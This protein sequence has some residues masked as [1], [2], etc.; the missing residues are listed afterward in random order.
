MKE[1]Q[2]I[3]EKKSNPVL[4]FFSKTLNGMA[5]GL[6]ATLIIGT[7]FGTIGTLFH[8]GAGNGFCDFMYYI[9]NDKNGLAFILQVLTGAGI[10]V[11][12]ALALKF[13]PLKTVV[14]AAVGEVAALFSLSTKFVTNPTD[15]NFF[16]ISGFKIG[17]P[18]TIY[19]VCIA[20]A[21]AIKYTLVKKTPVDILIVPLFG[22]AV[23][24]TA[25]L[26]IRYPAIY[27]T[28]GIQWLVNAGTTAVPFV[29]GIVVAVLMGMAL[30]APISSAAIAAMIFVLPQ[31]VTVSM[32]LADPQLAGLVVASGAAVIGCSTQMVGFAIQSRKD[33]P[34]G[35]VIS[36]GIG[37]S[38]LQ[39]KNILKNPLIWLPTIIASAILGPISTCWIKVICTGSSAG[40]GTAG[41]V[42]Q[43]GTISSM[44]VDNWQVWVGIFVLQII[45]PAAIVFGLDLL[46][47][48][49]GWIKDGDLKV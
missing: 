15:F 11:G 40:M 43:I 24:L 7:I 13:D 38:M 39:F 16:S 21:L 25:S 4:D 18:L 5:Y 10:G 28:Y 20:A 22:L 41:L 31:G 6:F 8:Y 27:V 29:M 1:T 45:A 47:R 14:L 48:K 30:T 42:G 32:A 44:G 33:N 36:I 26:L 23:G 3:Q 37:T 17:D 35:M 34:I 19:L 46:F 49:L 9:L 2:N 12:I